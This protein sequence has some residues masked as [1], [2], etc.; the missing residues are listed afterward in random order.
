MRGQDAA[1]MMTDVEVADYL[2]LSVSTIRR[3]RLL[4]TGSLPYRRFSGSIRYWKAEVDEWIKQQPA[5]RLGRSTSRRLSPEL[6]PAV[7]V[8]AGFDQI[9]R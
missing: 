2:G 7:R 9:H 5:F 1:N 6:R 4:G 3:W 8:Q